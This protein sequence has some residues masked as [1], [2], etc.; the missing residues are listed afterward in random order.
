MFEDVL[1]I[2]SNNSEVIMVGNQ[3]MI[4]KTHG[5]FESPMIQALV[6]K[7]IQKKFL[8]FEY[9]TQSNLNANN[10]HF[11]LQIKANQIN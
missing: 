5:S 8:P 3:H 9:A 7:A 10:A 2:R 1:K 11:A 6:G 4:N